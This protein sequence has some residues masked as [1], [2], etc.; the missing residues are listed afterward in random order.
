MIAEQHLALTETFESLKNS[1]NRT[2]QQDPDF[3]GEVFL[4]CNAKEVVQ[5]CA[6]R[7]IDSIKQ[8][9]GPEV[10]VPEVKIQGHLDATFPYIMSHLQYILGELLR[11]SVQ[12]MVEKPKEG[13]TEVP[14]IEVLICETKHH[15]II[16]VGSYGYCLCQS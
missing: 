16:R 14:P 11:N 7:M 2:R 10:Q 5:L 13:N 4:K 1:P 3:V 12:A 9:H 6:N 8:A 15:V